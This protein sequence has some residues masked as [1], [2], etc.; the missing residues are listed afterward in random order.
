MNLYDDMRAELTPTVVTGLC[1]TKL[2]LASSSNTKK[3]RESSGRRILVW[4]L[5]I[6]LLPPSCASPIIPRQRSLPHS[7]RSNSRSSSS[8]STIS[9]SHSSSSSSISP[10][11][12][13]RSS[14]SLTTAE[15]HAGDQYKELEEYLARETSVTASSFSSPSSSFSSSSSSV[16]TSVA[17]SPET[18]SKTSRIATQRSSLLRKLVHRSL[19]SSSPQQRPRVVRSAGADF[20]R[21]E[22]HW[23]QPCH[24]STMA[25]LDQTLP[26]SELSGYIF[27]N[28]QRSRSHINSFQDKFAQNTLM[29]PN[30]T[31]AVMSLGSMSD[32]PPYLP[33]IPLAQATD[34]VSPDVLEGTTFETELVKVYEYLQRYAVGIEQVTLDQALYKADFLKEFRDLEHYLVT[35]LCEV[36]NAMAHLGLT[37]SDTITKDIMSQ[38]ARDS[39]SET[40]RNNRDFVILKEYIRGLRYM[41]DVFN[42]FMS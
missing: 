21:K 32:R 7:S 16:S 8:S 42:H 37:P 22:L 19:S 13:P 36:K 17:E 25:K 29:H 40:K 6:L 9:K 41:E 35:L 28:V 33:E 12:S 4:V 31:S 39:D 11:S 24:T 5:L 3:R 23:S 26:T 14:T 27:T 30:W 1:Q 10:N 18:Q 34:T 38:T 2:A 20:T 15:T